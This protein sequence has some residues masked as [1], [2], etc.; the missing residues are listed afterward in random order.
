MYDSIAWIETDCLLQRG[1]GYG[2]PPCTPQALGCLDIGTR[3]LVLR[4]GR[5]RTGG[6]P[7]RVGHGV[8]SCGR[9]DGVANKR[10]RRAF[11]AAAMLSKES[12]AKHCSDRS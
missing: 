12:T 6:F 4:G 5:R 2:E 10:G 9:G 11:R 1:Y 3:S 8:S 7:F